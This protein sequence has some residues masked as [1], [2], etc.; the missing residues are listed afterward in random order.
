MSS[1]LLR[2][3]LWIVLIVVVLYVLQQTFEEGPVAEY[4]PLGMLQKTLIL[5]VLAIVAG[6]T[7]RVLE[8]GARV[9]HKNRCVVCKVAVP[10]GAIYCREHLRGMLE[11]EHDKT[12]TTRNRR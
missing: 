4:V 12:H 5:G 8:K 9:V 3:G 11:R 1:T 7:L 2:V 6:I 10:P